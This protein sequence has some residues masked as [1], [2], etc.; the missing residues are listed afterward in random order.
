MDELR[1][2]TAA[3]FAAR[4]VTRWGVCDFAPLADRLLPCRAL[5]RLPTRPRSVILALF[6]YRFADDSPRNLSRYAAVADYHR[7]T[8][9][10]MEEAAAA[11]KQAAPAHHFAVFCDNSPIPE[12]YAASLAGL[13]AVGDNGLLLDPVF[14]SYV[15]ISEI[16]TTAPLPPTG[17]TVTFCSHCGACAAACPGGCI[18]GDRA[19]CLSSLTQRKGELTPEEEQLIRQGGL[20]WGCDRCQEVCP[21]NRR[22]EIDPHPCF[23]EYRP[24]LTKEGLSDPALKEKPYGWRGAAPLRRNWELLYGE[25]DGDE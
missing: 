5:S 13:G 14:G 21:V 12:V 3:V 8:L 23:G 2:L 25:G 1:D 15:F 11:L 7:A 19:G 24:W 22:A 16:V 10:L 18:G 20:C 6:P 17:D 4:G 9:P